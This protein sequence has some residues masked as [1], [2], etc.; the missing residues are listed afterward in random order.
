MTSSIYLF[1]DTNFFVNCGPMEKIEWQASKDLAQA[2]DIHLLVCLPALQEIDDL[3]YRSDA[4]GQRAN[5]VY[6]MA[7]HLI[8]GNAAHLV[9]DSQGPTILLHEETATRPLPGLLDYVTADERIVGCAQSY[10]E[11]H[12]DRDVRFLTHDAGAMAIARHAGVP[13]VMVPDQW[14]ANPRPSAAE[15]RAAELEAELKR[16]KQTQ[17]Q[18]HVQVLELDGETLKGECVTARSLTDSEMSDLLNQLQRRFPGTST[19]EWID[20]CQRALRDL[21]ISIQHQSERMTVV[22]AVENRGSV[23]AK[24]AMIEIVG[25]GPILLG[26]PLAADDRR[27]K[28]RERPIRLPSPPSPFD[29]RLFGPPVIGPVDYSKL[30]P[31]EPNAFYY[32]PHRPMEP[33]ETI[34]WECQQWRHG[35]ETKH[36]TADIYADSESPITE[37]TIEI[38]IHA[39]NLPTP[40]VSFVRVQMTCH[41]ISITER[42]GKLIAEVRPRRRGRSDDFSISPF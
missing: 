21:H 18:F 10:R 25:H 9:I 24:D 34:T 1:P 15:R 40:A 13:L 38:R 42:A 29:N 35:A 23:P 16:L 30:P 20:D 11:D 39:E 19:P 7:R 17:P 2:D 28:Y 5:K 26:V 36:F 12:P 32:K 41:P 37:G 8:T 4:V 27:R 6:R 3:K 14:R 33:V 22:V 31:R